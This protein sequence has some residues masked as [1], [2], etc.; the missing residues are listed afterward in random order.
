MW[1]KPGP[2]REFSGLGDCLV[3]IF[4]SDGLR[5]LYQGFGVSVQGIIIYR[6]SYFG[7][8]DTAKADIMYSGTL[9]C[10]R[11]IARDEGSKAFFKGAWSNVLRGMGGAFVLVL[12]DEIKKY[13]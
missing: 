10:W 13:T 11:K 2:D 9:D 4:R 8:Y 6:A 3:K 12:Y 1:V 5:G 7:I